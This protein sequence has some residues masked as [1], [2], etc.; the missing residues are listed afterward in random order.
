M[1]TAITGIGSTTADAADKTGEGLGRKSLVL[2]GRAC[3]ALIFVLAG[4]SLFSQAAIRY[5]AAHGVPLAS[6]VVPISGVLAVLGGLSVALG[7]KAKWGA[8]TPG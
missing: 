5:A 8:W 3:Y 6:I 2:L 1:D 4:P 7:Y